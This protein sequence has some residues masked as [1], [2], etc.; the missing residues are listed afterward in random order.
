MATSSTGLHHNHLIYE[1][2]DSSVEESTQGYS[3]RTVGVAV[4]AA[5]SAATDAHPGWQPRSQ[6]HPQPDV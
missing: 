2:V 6:P 1:V 4:L 3:S 5:P